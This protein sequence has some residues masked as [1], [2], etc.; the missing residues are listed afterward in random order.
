MR[1]F[2]PGGEIP[3]AGH[4]TLGTAWVLREAG[5]L[6][7]DSAVQNCRAGEIE[8][9]FG[10][11]L[12]ALNAPPRDLAECPAEIA[13]SLLADLGLSADD[14][15]GPAYV[16]GAGLSFVFLPVRDDAVVRA[17]ASS[18]SPTAYGDLG[19]SDPIGGIS[20]YALSRHE[21]HRV[22]VHARVFCPEVAV[23]EDAATGS[24]AAGLGMALVAAGVLGSGGHYLIRQG[25]EMGRP[26]TL[27]GSVTAA[28]RVVSSIS[29]AGGVQP[30]ASGEIRVPPG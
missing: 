28:D 21:Q 23:P 18:T 16:A 14:L 4:P 9:R 7:G 22:D 12:V 29:V 24:A 8:V 3:F 13:A 30:I 11:D 1:I 26:S 15:D 2:T 6:T 5:I 17:H 20:V 19:V 25:L 27:H 10:D